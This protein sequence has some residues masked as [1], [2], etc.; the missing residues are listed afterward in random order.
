MIIIT[1]NLIN[2]SF[3]QKT[4]YWKVYRGF[5]QLSRNCTTALSSKE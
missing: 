3:D 2:W 4:Y 1:L 5:P